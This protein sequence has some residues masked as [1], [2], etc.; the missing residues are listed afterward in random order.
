MAASHLEWKQYKEKVKQ[1]TSRLLKST[2]WEHLEKFPANELT[3]Y[4]LYILFI[5]SIYILPFPQSR[6]R[7]GYSMVKIQQD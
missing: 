3:L 2:P 6:L 7:A 5:I 4:Y 1:C